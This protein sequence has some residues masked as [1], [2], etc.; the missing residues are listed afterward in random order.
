MIND[1]SSVIV[2]IFNSISLHQAEIKEKKANEKNKIRNEMQNMKNINKIKTDFKNK[3]ETENV[4][5]NLKEID[6]DDNDIIFTKDEKKN[7]NLNNLSFDEFDAARTYATLVLTLNGLGL[8]FHGSRNNIKNIYK[9]ADMFD[10]NNA[11]RKK[12]HDT[13]AEASGRIENVLFVNSNNIIHHRVADKTMKNSEIV[14]QTIF[15]SDKDGNHNSKILKIENVRDLG[16]KIGNE[17]DLG[18]K[19]GNVRDLGPKIGN[20]RDLG[21]KMGNDNGDVL[22]AILKG[23]VGLYDYETQSTTSADCHSLS[24]S[25]SLFSLHPDSSSISSVSSSSSS[26]SSLT[27]FVSSSSSPSS[28][29]LSPSSTSSLPSSTSSLPPYYIRQLTLTAHRLVTQDHILPKITLQIIFSLISMDIWQNVT[30]SQLSDTIKHFLYHI[31]IIHEK[32]EILNLITIV[33]YLITATKTTT[34]K[35]L[36]N[37]TNENILNIDFPLKLTSGMTK[38]MRNE[39]QI[40][41]E[42]LCQKILPVPLEKENENENRYDNENINMNEDKIRNEKNKQKTNEKTEKSLSVDDFLK[43]LKALKFS[44]SEISDEFLTK[45]KLSAEITNSLIFSFSTLINDF[46]IIE[47]FSALNYFYDLGFKWTDFNENEN[48]NIENNEIENNKEIID[49]E[50]LIDQSTIQNEILKLFCDSNLSK[51]QFEN[52]KISLKKFGMSEKV[53]SSIVQNV[54]QEHSESRNNAAFRNQFISAGNPVDQSTTFEENKNTILEKPIIQ[55]NEI[56]TDNT[57]PNN[58]IQQK[59]L[60]QTEKNKNKETFKEQSSAPLYVPRNVPRN[61]PKHAFFPAWKNLEEL[62]EQFHL[63]YGSPNYAPNV[64]WSCYQE[65]LTVHTLLV[66]IVI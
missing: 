13:I 55:I 50:N 24:Q 9:S 8:V 15:I 6:R 46:E 31:D 34:I 49:N 20:V 65:G 59:S 33:P 63:L 19:I 41:M 56:K 10:E 29:S 51:T 47:I 32:E 44:F 36:E 57:I 2:D 30:I 54:P 1:I 43:I 25:T 22:N 60:K 28:T 40:L 3:N 18:P 12:I 5:V 35:N 11:D 37:K 66:C 38:R 21:L 39:I 23:L 53:A 26:S 4:F 7:K 16:P 52:L 64:L 27:S 17:R 45:K 48:K 58:L 62:K 42:N 61:V 14:D